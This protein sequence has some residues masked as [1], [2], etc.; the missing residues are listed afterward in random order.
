M[1]TP[2][3]VPPGGPVQLSPAKA[4]ALDEVNQALDNMRQ[5]QQGGNFADFGSALQRLDDAMNRYRDAR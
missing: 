5:A 3:A 4:A 2:V 1:P